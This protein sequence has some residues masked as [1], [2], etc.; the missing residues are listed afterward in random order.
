[1]TAGGRKTPPEGSSSASA[2]ALLVLSFRPES[3]GWLFWISRDAYSSRW[4]VM[5]SSS[6]VRRAF[7]PLIAEGLIIRSSLSDDALTRRTMRWSLALGGPLT[8]RRAKSA[9][10]GHLSPTFR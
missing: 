7:V 9:G 5:K 10:L 1:M 3:R 2:S 8:I 6:P 4:M